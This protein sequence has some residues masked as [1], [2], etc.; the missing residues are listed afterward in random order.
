M[1]RSRKVDV[2]EDKTRWKYEI[3]EGRCDNLKGYVFDFSAIW[4]AGKFTNNIWDVIN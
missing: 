2:N 4:Q 3:F 1:S